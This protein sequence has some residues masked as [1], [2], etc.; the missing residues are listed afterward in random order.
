M[1]TNDFLLDTVNIII[2]KY[3]HKILQKY[4]FL[5]HPLLKITFK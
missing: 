4:F 5:I 3:I 1:G 2:L